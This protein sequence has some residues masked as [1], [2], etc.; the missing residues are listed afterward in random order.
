MSYVRVLIH[1]GITTKRRRPCLPSRVDPIIDAT[2]AH[3]AKQEG[4]HSLAT[5]ASVDHLHGLLAM[6][7]TKQI[8]RLIGEFKKA[9][10][11]ALAEERVEVEFADGYWAFSV[12]ATNSD[13]VYNYVVNQRTHHAGGLSLDN[14]IGAYADAANAKPPG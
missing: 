12:S 14:E 11:R 3:I 5:G 8:S 7:S 10:K 4:C 1:W 13:S 6:S 2:I 9:L